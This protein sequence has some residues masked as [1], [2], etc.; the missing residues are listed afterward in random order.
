MGEAEAEAEEEEKKEQDESL[1][2]QGL[3][4][5]QRHEYSLQSTPHLSVISFEISVCHCIFVLK[6]QVLD[7]MRF[8]R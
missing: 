6:I 2:N 3:S 7:Q 4:S 1:L 8:W 5:D